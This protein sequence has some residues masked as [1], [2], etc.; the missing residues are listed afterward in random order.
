MNRRVFLKHGLSVSAAVVLGSVPRFA[1]GASVQE[2][3]WR[4]F[5]VITP[6]DVTEAVG[7]VRAWVPVPLMNTTEYFQREP[8]RWTGNFTSAQAI[9]YDQ[10]GTGMVFAEWAADEPAPVLE[11]TSRFRTRDRQ[12]DLSRAPTPNLQEG[13]AVLQY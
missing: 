11:V 7:A 8:D 3:P 5:E 4:T 10:Y 6:L 1:R 13:Q 2:A 12:V 9:Q